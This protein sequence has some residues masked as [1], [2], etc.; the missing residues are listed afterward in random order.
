MVNTISGSTTPI[1]PGMSLLS[2]ARV[3]GVQQRS[4]GLAITV[5]I[6]TSEADGHPVAEQYFVSFVPKARSTADIGLLPPPHGLPSGIAD[7]PAAVAFSYH[8]DADQAHRFSD[9]SEDRDPYTTDEAAA[10]AMGFATAI[11]H[12]TCILAFAGR[13]AIDGLCDGNPL[14]LRRFAARLANPVSMV[15]GQKIVTRFWRND[16]TTRAAYFVSSDAAGVPVL[17][18]GRVE[19]A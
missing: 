9:A 10:R 2:Q 4:S 12:G 1:R 17:T 15:P 16:A 8:V 11:L 19:T 5:R 14:R 7:R 3:H 6:E 13:A 18:N